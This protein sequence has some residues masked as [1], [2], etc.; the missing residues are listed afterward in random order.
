MRVLLFALVLLPLNAM[1]DNTCQTTYDASCPAYGSIN[2]TFSTGWINDVYQCNQVQV[3][4]DPNNPT[5]SQFQVAGVCQQQ[6]LHHTVA[7]YTIVDGA[8]TVDVAYSFNS[9]F[10]E[11]KKCFLI[12]STHAYDASQQKWEYNSWIFC[13]TVF[14]GSFEN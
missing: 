11:Y 5:V 2:I 12:N 10:Q 4:S 8:F 6:L 1:A 14:D 13:D 3:V 7:P 9:T